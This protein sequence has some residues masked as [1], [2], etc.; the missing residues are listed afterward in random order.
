MM[1]GYL[2]LEARRALRN[3]RFLFFT[4]VFPVLL[5]LIWQ[6]LY[7]SSYIQRTH[8]QYAGYLMCS[9]AAF[10]A[11]TAAMNTGARVAEERSVGWQRQ[12]RLTPLSPPGY[13][14]S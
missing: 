11:L 1:T 3:P 10:G 8:I 2:A 12:L 5:F 14:L 9:M 4:L 6:G 7:G 13:L